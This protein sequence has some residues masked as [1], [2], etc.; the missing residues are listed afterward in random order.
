MIDPIVCHVGNKSRNI[1]HNLVGILDDILHVF[2]GFS[3]NK[4]LPLNCLSTAYHEGT[5]ALIHRG[6]QSKKV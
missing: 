2:E 4:T 6:P 3:M 1:S 5:F